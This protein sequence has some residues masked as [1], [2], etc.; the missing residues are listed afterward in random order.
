MNIE[1]SQAQQHESPVSYL[2]LA[3]CTLPEAS[4][5]SFRTQLRLG[6]LA[7]GAV[8]CATSSD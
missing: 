8:P 3:W 2:R 1:D 5:V 4:W 6:G 7:V